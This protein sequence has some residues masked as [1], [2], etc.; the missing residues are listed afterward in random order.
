VRPSLGLEVHEPIEHAVEL[1][2]ETDRVLVMGTA[3]GIKSVGLD[4]PTPE[5]ITALVKTR[6]TPCTPS[7]PGTTLRDGV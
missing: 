5:R 4:P 1:F 7:G 3:I 2:D 6:S